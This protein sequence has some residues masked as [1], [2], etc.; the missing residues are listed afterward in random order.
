MEA[1]TLNHI[2]YIHLFNLKASRFLTEKTKYPVTVTVM[3]RDMLECT[4][5]IIPNKKVEL[6]IQCDH[7]DYPLFVLGKTKYDCLVMKAD[8]EDFLQYFPAGRSVEKSFELIDMLMLDNKIFEQT[9]DR[10][11]PYYTEHTLR[12]V[13]LRDKKLIIEALNKTE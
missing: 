6:T 7:P 1:F 4:I 12:S 2:C 10:N 9:Y 8:R 11:K 13:Y 3:E 5:E